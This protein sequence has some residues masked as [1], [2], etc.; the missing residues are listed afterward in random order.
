MTST[1]T[2]PKV[3]PR[4]AQLYHRAYVDRLTGVGSRYALEEDAESTDWFV[5]YLYDLDGFKAINDTRGHR[6]G[7]MV[8]QAF[9]NTLVERHH[10]DKVYRLGGDEFVVLARDWYLP[11]PWEGPNG[12]TA[13]S[14]AAHRGHS[15]DEVLN[16]ADRRM[17]AGK[18]RKHHL[19]G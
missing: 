14:G 5:L 13:T 1:K 7:D 17:Y 15:F 6:Y 16:E 4:I 8:L 12:V 19:Q 10:P 18:G 2:K 9:A 3:M 11:E